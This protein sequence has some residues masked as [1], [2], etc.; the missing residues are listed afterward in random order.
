MT[1]AHTYKNI[2]WKQWS[3]LLAFWTFIALFIST[4]LYFNTI[5]NGGNPKWFVIFRDQLPIWY[6]WALIT[7]MIL[8]IINR[9][10]IGI[11]NV[12]KPILVY[13]LFGIG[14]L[15]FVTNLSLV[16]MFLT[17]GY[18]D[19]SNT[20]YGE[21]SPYFYSRIANDALIYVFVLTLLVTTRSYSLRKKNELDMALLQLKNDRLEN[22]LTRAQL[23]ALKL[24]LNPHFL[25]NTLHTISSLT[26]I[27]DHKTSA[28]V[29]TRLGDFLRRTLDYEEH[30]LV[31]LSKELEFFD[32]YLEIE[33]VR[34]GDRLEVQRTIDQECLN[35]KVPNL[36]LQPLIENAVKHGIG[37][38]RDARIVNLAI[39]RTDNQLKISLYNDGPSLNTSNRQGI[40]LQNIRS[41]LAKLY[42]E[43]SAL[44]I[45]D[46]LSGKG[47]N[48]VLM[49]PIV[50][51]PEYV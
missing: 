31:S 18:I 40:G 28:N 20:N 11:K 22:Q 44:E 26:L 34:F 14:L 15:F 8:F 38:S 46:D 35:I 6:F 41:R 19:L 48:S 49:I 43:N 1:I 33:S 42:P 29:A 12:M 13:L 5:K 9:Y 17:H 30:Q 37:K 50:E 23:Q 27:G 25:F 45:Q 51:K 39:S 21:Y 2:K 7:P 10:P 3:V 16:Y 47:V 24:Q 4:Q 32:L 36:I